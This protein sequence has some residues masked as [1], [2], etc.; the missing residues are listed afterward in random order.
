MASG[1]EKL[2][3]AMR[4]IRVNNMHVYTLQELAKLADNAEKPCARRVIIVVVM[5]LQG[6]GAEAIAEILGCSDASVC[7]YIN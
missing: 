6:I 2:I 4:R 7:I 5:V 3:M 1:E